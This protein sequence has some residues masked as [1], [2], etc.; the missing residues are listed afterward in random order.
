MLANLGYTTHAWNGAAAPLVVVGR[1]A[2]KDDPAM[3]AKLEP[4]VQAGGRVL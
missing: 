4:Y 2:L 3:A 1:N